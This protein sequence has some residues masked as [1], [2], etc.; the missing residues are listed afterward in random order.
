MSLRRQV[1]PLLCALVYTSALGAEPR[2]FTVGVWGNVEIDLPEGWTANPQG[3]EADG[4]A[5]IRIRPPSET[6]LELLMTPFPI[7]GDAENLPRAVRRAVEETAA[8]VKEVAVEDQLPIR[9]LK[10]PGCQ[11]LYFSATDRTVETPSLS[12]FKYMDQGAAAVGR[13]MMTFTVLTNVAD[14]PERT[15]ALDVVRSS[16]HLPPG[17]PWRVSKGSF[18][19]AFPGKTWRLTLD[20]PGYD[21]GPAELLP[22][23]RGV[24]LAGTNPRTQMIISVFLE[25][26]REGWTAVD[27]REDYW[28][29]IRKGM[30]VDREDVQRSERGQMAILEFRVPTIEGA[31]VHRKSLNAF[32][33]RDGVWIDVHL[34]KGSFQPDDQVLFDQVLDSLRFEQ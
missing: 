14:A 7:P 24:K 17:P 33:V 20:L 32:V 29:R 30:R 31:P 8:K 11:G 6:P 23:A 21:I 13:L 18:A 10:G 25:K 22:E 16:R 1:L 9:E 3:P 27:H 5:A 15:K 26:A 12:D 28:K 19:L 34:S 2:S 4:G